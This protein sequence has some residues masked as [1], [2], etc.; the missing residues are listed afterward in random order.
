MRQEAGGEVV[1]RTDGHGADPCLSRRGFNRG[2]WS[3]RVIRPEKSCRAL[4][5]HLPPVVSHWS[6]DA[7][8]RCPAQE[9]II[10]E[11]APLTGRRYGH[12]GNRHPL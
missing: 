6:L 4:D 3:Y 10:I 1:M 11:G 9:H 2:D 8:L 7:H 5:V 12:G